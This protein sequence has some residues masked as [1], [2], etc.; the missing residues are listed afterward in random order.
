MKRPYADDE[1]GCASNILPCCSTTP[2]KVRLHRWVAEI[3]QA[4]FSGWTTVDRCIDCEMV[5]IKHRKYLGNKL[6]IKHYRLEG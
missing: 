2:E 6:S 1:P 5:R 4:G 3:D